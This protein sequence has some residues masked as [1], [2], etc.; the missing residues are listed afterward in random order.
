[1]VWIDVVYSCITRVDVL[2][3][4][5]LVNINKRS[6]VPSTMICA[7]PVSTTSNVSLV[8]AYLPLII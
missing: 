8:V 2:S 7:A 3:G 4:V 6:E 5:V 1:M